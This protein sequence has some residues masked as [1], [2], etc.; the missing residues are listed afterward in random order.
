MFGIFSFNHK[1]LRRI[2]TDYGFEGYPLR[3]EFPLSGFFEIYYNEITKKI[4][5]DELELMQEYRFFDFKSPWEIR[6]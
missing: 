4:V 5:Y 3:K 1:D 6:I 2:S